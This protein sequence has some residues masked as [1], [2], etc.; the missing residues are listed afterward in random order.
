MYPSY[1]GGNN[2]KSALVIVSKIN[3]ERSYTYTRA[4]DMGICVIDGTAIKKG[5]FIDEIKKS[6]NIKPH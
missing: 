2:S 1:F 6:L 4:N 3:K 5:K